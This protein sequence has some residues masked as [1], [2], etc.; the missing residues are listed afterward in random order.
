MKKWGENWSQ[1][2]GDG[3]YDGRKFCC[4]CAWNK[5]NQEH[6]WMEK[7]G[8]PRCSE[9]TVHGPQR[10][11]A[12]V[13]DTQCAAGGIHDWKVMP[14]TSKLYCKKCAQTKNV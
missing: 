9:I 1:P 4:I 14:G 10:A 2:W 11:A 5:N 8:C 12:A 13:A 3:T 7:H 6:G